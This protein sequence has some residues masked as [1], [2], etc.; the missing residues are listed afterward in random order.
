[1][2]VSERHFL[3]K[4]C[5]LVRVLAEAKK[6]VEDFRYACGTRTPSG[7]SVEPMKDPTFVNLE[8]TIENALNYIDMMV[9]TDK[10]PPVVVYHAKD[11]Q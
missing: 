6:A 10:E 4:L 9:D 2:I 8:E 11:K 7:H 1:M 3:G 5:E